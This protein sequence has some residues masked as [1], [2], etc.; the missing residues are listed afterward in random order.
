MLRIFNRFNRSL[1]NEVIRADLHSSLLDLKPGNPLE[2]RIEALKKL[3]DWTKLPVTVGD[4]TKD[5]FSS[6]TLR[7]KFLLNF[8]ERN[9]DVGKYFFTL[10]SELISRGMTIRLLYFTGISDNNGFFS[11]ISDRLIVKILPPTLIEKDLA[12]VCRLLFY[13]PEDIIWFEQHAVNIIDTFM[14]VA[15][16]YEVDFSHLVNDLEDALII[17]GS[18]ISSL[19]VSKE[20]RRHLQHSE[21][22]DSSFV[23]LSMA[24]NR[25]DS[26]DKILVE[27]IQCRKN[28]LQVREK[29]ETSGVSVHLIYMIEKIEAYLNRI[30]YLLHLRYNPVN[31]ALVL[32]FISKLLSDEQENL[33]VKNFIHHNIQ[34]LTRKIVERAG[35]KGDH[36]IADTAKE[37]RKLFV[38]ASWAG[39]L[40]AFTAIIKYWIGAGN[41]PYFFEGFFFFINYAVSFL[42]MQYWHLALSSKQPAYT[43]SALSRKFEDFKITRELSDIILEVKKISYSQ[44]LA[45]IGNFLW[46][47]PLVYLF[48]LFHRFGFG[49]A[50]MSEKDAYLTISKHSIF[51][52]MTLIYAAFTGVLLWL[53]SVIA[54]WTENWI[55]YRNIPALIDQSKAIN[56]ILGQKKTQSFSESLPGILSGVAGCLSISFFLAAPIII[57]KI[58]GIP[59]DIRHV[60]LAAGTVTLA[61]SSIS[62]GLDQWYI[63]VDML[64]SITVIGILNFGISFYCAI[65]MAAIARNVHSKYLKIILKFV[66]T[67][68]KFKKLDTVQELE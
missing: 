29:L 1:N 28:I 31:S 19:G 56:T 43:A 52:S 38:A 34:L 33:G 62:P 25:W 59:L 46:V 24:I 18:H 4:E 2:S 7:T 39:V 49:N 53:S 6:R 51:T 16:K 42:L 26:P 12:E 30:E 17:L 3:I 27:L 41:L 44:F 21:L 5:D 15:Q 61:I 64:I 37:K 22:S 58:F 54:G 20:I 11:E 65:R 32:K 66:I 57:G 68:K 8:L 48:D 63:Y 47:V 50:I 9:E 45:F 55:V 40:T 35:N 67:R 23:K 13:N 60:T 14:N 36:Y 10:F